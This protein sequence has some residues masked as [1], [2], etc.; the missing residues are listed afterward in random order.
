MLILESRL[1][2]ICAYQTVSFGVFKLFAD[3]VNLTHRVK[4]LLFKEF[5]DLVERLKVTLG[6]HIIVDTP[7]NKQK[8][9]ERN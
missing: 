7:A 1:L 6:V 9:R 5:L 2:V 4:L 8:S 3:L